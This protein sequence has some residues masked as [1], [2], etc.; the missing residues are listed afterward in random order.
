VKNITEMFFTTLKN[1]T[2]ININLTPLSKNYPIVCVN[3]SIPLYILQNLA[4][5]IIYYSAVYKYRVLNRHYGF[6]SSSSYITR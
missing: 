6:S 1:I 3:K 5:M 4:S 2:V